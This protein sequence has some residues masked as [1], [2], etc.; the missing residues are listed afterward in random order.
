MGGV[1][2]K[3]MFIFAIVLL[4]QFYYEKIFII[5]FNGCYVIDSIRSE[6]SNN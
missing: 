6:R 2:R 5:N 4:N 1:N 3:F